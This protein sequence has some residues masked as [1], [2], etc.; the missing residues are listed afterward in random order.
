MSQ[1]LSDEIHNRRQW[2]QEHITSIESRLRCMVQRKLR[3]AGWYDADDILSS[4][5]R[6]LDVQVFKVELPLSNEGQLNRLI[7]K[8]AQRVA[9]EKYR[10][11]RRQRQLERIVAQSAAEV[12][13]QE[14]RNHDHPS[15]ETVIPALCADDHRLLNLWMNG[16]S[17]KQI[18]DDLG[19]T[20]EAY[21]TR[22]KRLIARLRGK[23]VADGRVHPSRVRKSSS[24]SART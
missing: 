24:R 4:A 2:L 20:L 9:L 11:A 3:R 13:H 7:F 16:V 5:R 21:R 12:I 19:I 15:L 1:N 6:C 14:S 17:Q 22:R 23:L 18:A 10:T 8:V